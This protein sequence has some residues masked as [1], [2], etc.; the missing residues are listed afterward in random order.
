MAE[1]FAEIQDQLEIR[2]KKLS[3]KLKELQT[4][5]EEAE[6]EGSSTVVAS[7]NETIS[8]ILAKIDAIC[9][10]GSKKHDEMIYWLQLAAAQGHEEAILGLKKIEAVELEA[11]SD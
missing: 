11:A 9:D 7:F 6:S 10:E 3:K 4:M 2:Y 1:Y 5:L 8:K